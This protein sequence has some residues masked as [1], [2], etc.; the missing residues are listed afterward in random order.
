MKI[1]NLSVGKSK[2]SFS[3]LAICQLILQNFLRSIASSQ[4]LQVSQKTDRQGNK[5]WQAYN[6]E[7]GSSTSLSSEAEMRVWIEQHYYQSN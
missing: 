4:E 1:S 2:S 7:T 5:Y 6:P 3:L